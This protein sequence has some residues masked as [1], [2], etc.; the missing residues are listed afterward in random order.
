MFCFDAVSE[1]LLFGS[2]IESSNVLGDDLHHNEGG[3]G[4]R[5]PSES[6]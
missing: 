4:W 5:Y 2:T 6:L 3:V 1:D